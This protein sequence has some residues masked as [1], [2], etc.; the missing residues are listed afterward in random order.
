MSELLNKVAPPSS[1]GEKQASIKK[2]VK[3][4]NEESCMTDFHSKKLNFI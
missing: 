1:S 4:Q 2:T 3:V